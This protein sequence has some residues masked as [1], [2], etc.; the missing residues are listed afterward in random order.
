MKNTECIVNE[1]KAGQLERSLE[2]GLNFEKSYYIVFNT[3]PTVES[4]ERFLLMGADAV[5]PELGEKVRQ[6]IG[7]LKRKG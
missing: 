3:L 7:N 4:M 2:V 6:Q 5:S 1:M